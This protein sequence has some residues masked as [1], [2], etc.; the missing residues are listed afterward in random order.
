VDR[1]VDGDNNG[2]SLP[3]IGAVESYYATIS[4]KKFHDRDGDGLQDPGEEGLAGWTIFADLDGDGRLDSNELSAITNATGD[5]TIKGLI[6]RAYTVSEVAQPGWERT[7]VDTSFVQALQDDNQGGT[8]DSLDGARAMAITANDRFLFVA[9]ADEAKIARFERNLAT[10]QLTYLGATTAAQTV[11]PGGANILLGVEQL[12]I[13]TVAGV[14][15]LYALSPHGALSVF[16]VDVNTGAVTFAQVVLETSA[17][18]STVSQSHAVHRRHR[19]G[20]QPRR[21]APLCVE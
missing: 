1:P 3:D 6:P 9:G 5:Y 4:G 20:H 17:T 13:G 2:S 10:G 15:Q 16:T 19:P 21:H 8:V 7:H 12:V 14:T 11:T 18:L